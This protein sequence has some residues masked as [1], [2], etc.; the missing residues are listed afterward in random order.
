MTIVDTAPI[1]S[2]NLIDF[3]KDPADLGFD[4]LLSNQEQTPQTH[5]AHEAGNVAVHN[6]VELDPNLNE[7]EIPAHT[8]TKPE[9]DIVVTEHDGIA[10]RMQA[11]LLR[12]EVNTVD[13]SELTAD[14]SEARFASLVGTYPQ[15]DDR[16]RAVTVDSLDA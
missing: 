6:V 13:A 3:M 12:S 15:L 8:A 14:P 10:D 9:D 1:Q 2:Q 5:A 16:D 4:D 7:L 11:A